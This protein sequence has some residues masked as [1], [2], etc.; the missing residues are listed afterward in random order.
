[1]IKTG[2]PEEVLLAQANQLFNSRETR[3]RKL[4]NG[5]N[6]LRNSHAGSDPDDLTTDEQQY[7]WFSDFEQRH[8]TLYK[9]ILSTEINSFLDDTIRFNRTPADDEKHT[10]KYRARHRV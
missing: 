1:M 8:V 10:G 9:P 5:S 6:S 4:T 3:E 7:L 2:K